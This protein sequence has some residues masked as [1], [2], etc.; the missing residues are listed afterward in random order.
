MFP[1]GC[2][3]PPTHSGNNSLMLPLPNQVAVGYA[4]RPVSDSVHDSPLPT[5]PLLRE[6][7][8]CQSNSRCFFR[9]ILLRVH[10]LQM[11]HTSVGHSWQLLLCHPMMLQQHVDTCL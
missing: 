7:P 9:Q 6:E 3:H 2:H 10:S 4:C 11:L 5:P 1:E 8:F